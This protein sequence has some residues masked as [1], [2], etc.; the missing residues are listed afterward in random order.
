MKIKNKIYAPLILCLSMLLAASGNVCVKFLSHHYYTASILFFKSFFAL[1]FLFI[2]HPNLKALK[3]DVL[4]SDIK[5]NMLRAI[6]GTIGVWLW[7]YSVKYISLPDAATLGLT[8]SLFGSL[9][10][11]MFL[12]EKNTASKNVALIA[13]FIGAAIIIKPCFCSETFY[14]L[15]PI[16]SAFCFGASSVL[17]R[18][19]V[20]KN[21]EFVT[22]FYLF[23][24]MI[25]SSIISLK[26]QLPISFFDFFI[27]LFVGLFYGCSQLSYVRAYFY[28]ETSY[29]ANFKFLKVVIN[30]LLA[31]L[32][33]TETPTYSTALGFFLISLSLS[34]LIYKSK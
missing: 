17:A 12:R 6:V 24:M 14:Y 19:L 3:K 29:L 22:S 10:G 16:G 7:I 25:F 5:P 32:F 1:I 11:Y 4:K 2:Y 21:Q 20:L 9:L 26:I 34:L 23:C 13:G 33:F 18:F 30:T 28:E 8:S 27:F 15:L 31:Y